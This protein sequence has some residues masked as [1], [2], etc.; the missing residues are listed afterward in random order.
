MTVG[1]IVNCFLLAFFHWIGTFF[2]F[3]LSQSLAAILYPYCIS[4]CISLPYV[5]VLYQ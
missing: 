4:Y 5:D 1:Y 3:F 2:F